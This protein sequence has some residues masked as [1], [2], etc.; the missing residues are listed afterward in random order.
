MTSKIPEPLNL[1]KFIYLKNTM[2]EEETF[3]ETADLHEVAGLAPAGK[4]EDGLDLWI[5]TSDDWANY[6]RLLNESLMNEDLKNN[7]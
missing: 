3:D 2:F 7:N 6:E 4:D 1:Q 5:G